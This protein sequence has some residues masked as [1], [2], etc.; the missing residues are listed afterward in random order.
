MRSWES[1]SRIINNNFTHNTLTFN[2]DT[3]APTVSE[4][5]MLASVYGSGAFGDLTVDENQTVVLDTDAT[6]EFKMIHPPDV[7]PK[8]T[9]DAIIGKLGEGGGAALDDAAGDFWRAVAALAR[10]M[11]VG[12]APAQPWM[13][14]R[15]GG[16]EERGDRAERRWP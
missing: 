9:P 10:S 13:A 8:Y 15:S 1:I 6:E 2:Y 12:R 5:K 16:V 11:A 14:R 4:M 3:V 7:G